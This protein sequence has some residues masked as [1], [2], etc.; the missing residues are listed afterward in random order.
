MLIKIHG[1]PEFNLNDVDTI[2][3][4]KRLGRYC[5]DFSWLDSVVEDN[6]IATLILNSVPIFF[7]DRASRKNAYLRIMHAKATGQT[8]FHVTRDEIIK[9]TNINIRHKSPVRA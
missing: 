3:F 9:P 1:V 7:E 5:M 2:E 8:H 4:T 6:G